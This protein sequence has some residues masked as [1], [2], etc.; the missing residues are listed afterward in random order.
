M[1]LWRLIQIEFGLVFVLVL[2]PKPVLLVIELH[3]EFQLAL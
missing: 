1:L 2:G 3:F